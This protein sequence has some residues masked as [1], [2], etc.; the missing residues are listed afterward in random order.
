MSPGGGAPLGCEDWW[1][2]GNVISPKLSKAFLLW[3]MMSRSTV[4]NCPE[5]FHHLFKRAELDCNGESAILGSQN[6]TTLEHWILEPLIHFTCSGKHVIG[7]FT[8]YNVLN[9]QR[10]SLPQVFSGMFTQLIAFR[11]WY[12]PPSRKCTLYLAQTY[13]LPILC[14]TWS[15]SFFRLWILWVGSATRVGADKCVLQ[16]L[17]GS[18]KKL[19]WGATEGLHYS[20]LRNMGLGHGGME[21]GLSRLKR[22]AESSMSHKPAASTSLVYLCEIENL[23]PQLR[24]SEPDC[25]FE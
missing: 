9:H 3:L 23:R 18:I 17:K 6:P 20:I 5:G 13:V 11:S 4:S 19:N 8:R 22:V 1:A 15:V 14:C 2:S 12:S 24:Q 25:A 16:Y 7:P 10:W 21:N